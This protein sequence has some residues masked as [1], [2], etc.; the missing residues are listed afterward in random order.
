MVAE[1]EGRHR[2]RERHSRDDVGA[3]LRVAPDLLELFG[4]QRARLGDD[5][6]GNGQLAD[7]VEQRRGLDRLH[8][9]VGHPECP[10]QRGRV[11]LDATDV[12]MRRLILGVNRQRQRFDRRQVQ[13]G[14]LL[15]VTV[16]FLE[17]SRERPIRAERQVHDWR[18]QQQAGD[19]PGR[20][21]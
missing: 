21:L 20:Q 5:V 11:N 4:R 17:A 15:R 3:D 16:L 1:D 7:V 13:L 10:R 6:L 8:L 14:H 2:I 9:D 18:D 12:V 19:Q